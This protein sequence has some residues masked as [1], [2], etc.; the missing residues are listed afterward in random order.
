MTSATQLPIE[1]FAPGIYP[2]LPAEEYHADR[3]SLSSTGA[4]KILMASPATF[5]YELD[6]PPAPKKVF[7]LG[8]AVHKL[9][10]G[11]GPKLTVVPGARWD[12]KDAKA[13]LRDARAEGAVPL[14][15]HE[16]AQVQAMADAVRRHPDAARMFNPERGK[17]EQSLF[18]TDTATGVQCRARFDWLPQSNGGQLLVPDLKTAVSASPKAFNKAVQDFRYDQQAD[19]Y[20]DGAEQLELA[21]VAV[22]AFVIVEKTPPYLVNVIELSSGWLVMAAERNKRA[23]EIYRECTRSGVWP[24]YPRGIAMVDPPAWLETEH[25]REMTGP[26][27]TTLTASEGPSHV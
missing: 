11:D 6:N 2:E 22:M 4:R 27:A 23:R 15:E 20:T 12:T 16:H 7:D 10:L 17:P 8:T 14:K 21:E 19:H 13:R 24:G 18:W 25:E 3:T 26:A 5:R 9:V 1:G